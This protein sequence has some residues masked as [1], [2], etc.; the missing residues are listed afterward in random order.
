MTILRN[1]YG[2]QVASDV[3]FGPCTLKKEPLEMVFIRGPIIEKVGPGITVLA[4]HQGKPVLVQNG[5]I[6]AATFHPELT[7]D[8]TVHSHFLEMAAQAPGQRKV[9]RR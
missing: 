5:H 6:L 7:G 2:R 3:F 8:T 1:G 4:K 9:Q